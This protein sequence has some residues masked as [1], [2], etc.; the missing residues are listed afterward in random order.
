[1]HRPDFSTIQ[2]IWRLPSQQPSD[3]VGRLSAVHVM[4]ILLQNPPLG[5]QRSRNNIFI[6]PVNTAT[7]SVALVYSSA[8]LIVLTQPGVSLVIERL[9]E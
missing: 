7:V 5:C 2:S 9:I 8:Q 4:T 3:T 6:F 1:M